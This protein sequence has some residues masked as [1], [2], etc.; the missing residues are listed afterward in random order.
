MEVQADAP[1]PGPREADAQGVGHA[2]RPPVGGAG[3]H[4]RDAGVR[5][6]R[7]HEDVA[8]AGGEALDGRRIRSGRQL[9]P[10]Q[11]V[12]ARQQAR[13]DDEDGGSGPAEAPASHAHGSLAARTAEEPRR[14]VEP[15]DVPSDVT[16]HDH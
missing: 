16:S 2:A 8:L 12:P 6:S 14:R 3:Q 4:V 13:D 15:G 7:V 11:P 5:A 1:R 10:H 9:D